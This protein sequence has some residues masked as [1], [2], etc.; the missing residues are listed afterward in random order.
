VLLAV[1]V[2]SRQLPERISRLGFFILKPFEQSFLISAA[3]ISINGPLGCAGI[4]NRKSKR[5]S[6]SIRHRNRAFVAE[7]F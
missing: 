5:F 7:R 2:E 3:D 4:S 1:T 6:I